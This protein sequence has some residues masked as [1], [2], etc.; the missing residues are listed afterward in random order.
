MLF[1]RLVPSFWWNGGG[2]FLLLMGLMLEDPLHKH[3]VLK[4][5]Q[6]AY[7]C[8]SMAVSDA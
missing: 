7:I 4:L 2:L 8:F 1:A 3:L 6:K 5:T